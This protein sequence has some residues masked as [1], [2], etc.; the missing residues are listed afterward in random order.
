MRPAPNHQL[1]ITNY[2]SPITNH[3]LPIT[4]YQS[5]ITNH[6]LPITNYQSPIT[7]HQLPIIDHESPINHQSPITGHPPRQTPPNSSDLTPISTSW[8]CDS[9]ISHRRSPAT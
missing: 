8:L 9:L 5:P 2:Q 6:Q 3:Q 1:P 7:N 4:N